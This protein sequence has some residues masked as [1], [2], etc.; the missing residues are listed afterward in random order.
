MNPGHFYIG[1]S[2]PITGNFLGLS[3]K[4]NENEKKESQLLHGNAVMG[5]RS[6][7]RGKQ[8]II[9]PPS[10]YFSH[11][12]QKIRVF[13]YSSLQIPLYLSLG[14][15]FLNR[16]PFIIEFFAL[17]QSDFNFYQS[18]FTQKDPEGNNRVSFI[19]K[20]IFQL[21]EFLTV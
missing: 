11:S 7:K 16:F 19:L 18:L 13:T 17:S 4:Y 12:G 3:C 5:V 15:P 9:I 8:T 6:I 14:V 1:L 20:L 10:V 21:P 2:I